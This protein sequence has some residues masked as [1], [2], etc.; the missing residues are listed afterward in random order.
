MQHFWHVITLIRKAVVGCRWGRGEEER[1]QGYGR[2]G[3]KR[4]TGDGGFL[5]WNKNIT[6]FQ[7]KNKR[8]HIF[9]LKTPKRL[10][11]AKYDQIKRKEIVFFKIG[12]LRQASSFH[13]FT[14]TQGEIDNILI[15]MEI[16]DVATEQFSYFVLIRRASNELFLIKVFLINF[17][18]AGRLFIC[19]Y[20]YWKRCFFSSPSWL[21]YG[22]SSALW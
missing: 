14:E 9:K 22:N 1:G 19:R 12:E 20:D 5:V 10:C 3:R 7:K 17:H 4:G 15:N 2:G 16:R 8:S 11:H 6:H 13:I 18:L 21:N